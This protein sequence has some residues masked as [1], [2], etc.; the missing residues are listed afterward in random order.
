MLAGLVMVAV[1]VLS[2]KCRINPDNIATPIA[3]SLGD[4]TCLT[5]LASIALLLYKAQSKFGVFSATH[6]LDSKILPEFASCI[7][8]CVFIV[9]VPGI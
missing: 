4:L 5:L 9:W 7:T 3:A 8:M 1:V 2:R 6:L